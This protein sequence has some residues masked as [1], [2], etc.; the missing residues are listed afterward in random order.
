MKFLDLTLPTA[1]ENVALD[2]ALLANCEAEEGVREQLRIWE[3]TAPLIVV[4]RSSLVERELD[5]TSCRRDG[6]P[7]LRRVS[8]G[9][10]ILAAPGC[11]MY[12]LV[13]SYSWRPELR[14]IHAAHRYVL[15]TLAMSLGRH[16]VGLTRAGISDL[17]IGDRKVSGN[18][19]RCQRTHLLY[20]GTLLYN[21]PLAP[22]GRYLRMPPREPDYRSGRSHAEFLAQLPARREQIVLALRDAFEAQEPLTTW[23]TDR[24]QQLVASRYGTESWNLRGEVQQ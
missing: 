1:A 10:A 18:S 13:L 22:V 2:E 24:V 5:L 4:G 6:V 7:V 12:A 9:C 19:L 11:L 16:A 23:P 8:G 20:H 15:D 17:A 21:M 3:P 14:A